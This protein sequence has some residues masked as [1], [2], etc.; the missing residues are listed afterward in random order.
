VILNVAALKAYKGQAHLLGALALL[1]RQGYDAVVHLVGEGPERAELERLA[2]SLGVAA[3]VRFHGVL[4]GRPLRRLL[5]QAHVFAMPSVQLQSGL[6]EGIPVAVMEAMAVG[7]PVVASSVSGMPELVIDDVTGLLVPPADEEAL[8]A[9]VRRLIDQ[10]GLSERLSTSARQLVAEEF[11][12]RQTTRQLEGLFL[13]S[14][15]TA[16][17]PGGVTSGPV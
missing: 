8:A 2:N 5:E 10:P 16:T 15:V 11:D 17:E 9:A 7:V 12:L 4:S 1:R 13:E 14:L 6:T 3:A